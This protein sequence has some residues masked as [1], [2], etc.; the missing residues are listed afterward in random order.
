MASLKLPGADGLQLAGDRYPASGPT[1][2]LLLH[3]GGQ[4]RHAWGATG[5]TLAARGWPTTA[6]D[7]RGHGGSDWS[8]TGEYSVDGF[9]RDVGPLVRSLPAAPVLVGA[10]AGGMACLSALAAE[11]DL[12]IAGLVLVDVAHRFARDGAEWVADFMQSRRAGFDDA[13]QA[14]EAVAEYLPHRERPKDT[15]GIER[16]LRVR[17]GR[18]HWHWDPALVESLT[19]MLEPQRSER[20]QRRF[21]GVLERLRVPVL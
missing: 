6:V 5:E 11:P 18:L 15:A 4:T 14:G 9:G 7:L 10:S 8:P 17:G 19:A 2:V 21:G 20:D 1:P 12:P 13:D 16:N 3:G